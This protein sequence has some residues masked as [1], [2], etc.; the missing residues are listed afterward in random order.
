[1]SSR[2]ALSRE[3]FHGTHAA[4]DDDAVLRPTTEGYGT[5]ELH[6]FATTNPEVA[7]RSGPNIYK[8]VPVDE[9]D[10]APDPYNEDDSEDWKA[11]YSERPLNFSSR[12]G[13]RVV[14]RY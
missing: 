13:F 6:S 1:M 4:L 12:A 3:L 5:D 8:V 9:S 7:E 10:L 11:Q 2:D 14:G